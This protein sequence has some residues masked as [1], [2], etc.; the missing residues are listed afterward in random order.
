MGVFLHTCCTYSWI[1]QNSQLRTCRST[2]GVV[3]RDRGLRH[4]VWRL[5]L[6]T[7]QCPHCATCAQSIG[8]VHVAGGQKVAWHQAIVLLPHRIGDNRM[9]DV[10]HVSR[11]PRRNHPN[12]VGLADQTR[13]ARVHI[14]AMRKPQ[15]QWS[16]L[17]ACIY[18][19]GNYVQSYWFWYQNYCESFPNHQSK[20]QIIRKSRSWV[21]AGGIFATTSKW[22]AT[23]LIIRLMGTF[24]RSLITESSSW[25]SF[26]LY[27]L[28]TQ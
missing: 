2:D 26:L 10:V 25:K 1:D 27:Q 17:L 13:S 22:W 21:I 23:K 12:T 15:S 9:A 5:T 8:D 28:E 6:H 20:Y 11:D 16:V 4:P 7:I 24:D 3:C 19:N 14:E 18:K